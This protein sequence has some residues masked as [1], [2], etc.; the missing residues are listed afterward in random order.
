MGEAG[1]GTGIQRLKQAPQAAAPSARGH[2]EGGRER[3]LGQEEEGRPEAER[4][5]ESPRGETSSLR[6]GESYGMR[7]GA[8]EWASLAPG[9]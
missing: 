7:A 3:L 1:R 2:I 8:S 4:V 9:G 5:K 6:Q